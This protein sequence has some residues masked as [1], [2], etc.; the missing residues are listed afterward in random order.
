MYFGSVD[1]AFN[2]QRPQQLASRLAKVYP[3][4]YVDPPGLRSPR[5]SDW[6][7]VVSRVRTRRVPKT[8]APAGHLV[9]FSPMAYI[10]TLC[11]ELVLQLDTLVYRSGVERLLRHWGIERAILWMGVPAPLICYLLDDSMWDLVIYD[12]LDEVAS[13]HTHAHLDVI[14]R[15]EAFLAGRADIV[16]ASATQLCE[17][18]SRYNPNTHLLPNAAD[19]NHFYQALQPEVAQRIPEDI[20]RIPSPIVGYVGGISH[21]FDFELVD[22]VAARRPDVSVVIIGQVEVSADLPPCR[23]NLFF[24]G[25]KPYDS[26]PNYLARFDVG[27]IPFEVNHL[28]TGVSPVKLFEY[29]FCY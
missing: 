29:L 3:L 21:W 24:L 2:R 25:Q 27:I 18:M 6:R 10:P 23:P 5:L 28:T 15:T 22:L 4:V 16:F 14:E 12:C 9:V 26:L 1:W 17:K 7:R 13:F 20:A 11:N 8:E 19:F